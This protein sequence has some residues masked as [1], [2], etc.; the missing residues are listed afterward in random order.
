MNC[1]QKATAA[2]QEHGAT[3]RRHSAGKGPPAMGRLG[4][5]L[6]LGMEPARPAQAW[7]GW[8]ESPEGQGERPGQ[9]QPEFPHRPGDG[10]LRQP[11]LER[12]QHQ[13]R[14]G[15]WGRAIADTLVRGSAR[16]WTCRQLQLP[17]LQPACSA[18]LLSCH[19]SA[20]IKVKHNIMLILVHSIQYI[21]LQFI[22]Q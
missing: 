11:R 1:A 7:G 9:R 17:S 8:A 4:G 13:L 22:K 3:G 2:L 6:V 12:S 19:L 10:W 21:G 20:C 16:S 18:A 15:G 14:A 5:K